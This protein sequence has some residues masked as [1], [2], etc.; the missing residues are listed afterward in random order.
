MLKTEDEARQCWCPFARTLDYAVDTA[1]QGSDP[2]LVGASVNRRAGNNFDP[3]I[4][5]VASECMAWRW[6]GMRKTD[7]TTIGSHAAIKAASRGETTDEWHSVGYCGL[8]GKPEG[9]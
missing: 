2:Q 6:G 5:C 9:A 7:G 8:V 3:D 4:M 1:R